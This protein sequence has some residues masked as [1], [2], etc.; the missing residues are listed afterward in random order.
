M[1]GCMILY[2]TIFCYNAAMRVQAIKTHKITQEDTDILAIVD[3]YVTEM[4]EGSILAVTS[5]IV[6]LCEGRV[7]KKEGTDKQEL[8]ARES[9][10]YL[11]PEENKYHFSL[12]VKQGLL[13]PTAGI[14]ESNAQGVYVL[15][16]R[17][18][19]KTA[20]SIREFLRKN[21]SL[22]RVGVVITDSTTRPLRWGVTGIAVAHSGFLALNDFRGKPDIF[23]V[24]LKVTQ[25]NVADGLAAVAVLSMGESNEQTPLAV[26]ED[27]P[28]V[29][30]QDRN[31]TAEELSV[32]RISLEEDLYA[33]L[34]VKAPWKKGRA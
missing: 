15:W 16:P 3:T 14:D 10:L 12:A 29:Q 28:F 34:L 21:F 25:V 4:P 33:P 9:E 22:S 20:D 24:P 30:F 27:V 31:P 26:V 18:A 8:V 23:G 19:Q 6:S 13:I 11:S 5:K 17:D 1:R 2:Y 7:V 32:L